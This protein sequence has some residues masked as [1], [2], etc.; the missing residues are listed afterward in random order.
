[1]LG[2]HLNSYRAYLQKLT[3]LGWLTTLEQIEKVLS[4]LIPTTRWPEYSSTRYTVGLGE[5]GV[6]ML[7]YRVTYHGHC[8]EGNT[9]HCAPGEHF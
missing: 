8:G 3:S 9:A 1:M 5:A 7:V 6:W 4:L 2:Y